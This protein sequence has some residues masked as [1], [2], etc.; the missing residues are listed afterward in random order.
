M[1]Q[2]SKKWMRLDNAANIYPA[3]RRRGWM[4][5]FR[6]SATLNEKINPVILQRAQEI[7]LK[8][9]PSMAVKLKRGLFWY[10]LERAEGGPQVSCD[11]PYPC[12]SFCVKENGGFGFRVKYY[13]NRIA[14][15]VFHVLTD[16]TGGIIFLKTL[17]AEYLRL[18]HGTVIPRGQEIF[19]CTQAP[20]P[21][22]LED[23]FWRYSGHISHGRSE[24][25]AYHISG[26]PEEGFVNLTTGLLPVEAVKAEAQ[27]MGVTVTELLS[28]VMIRA[29][30]RLQAAERPAR[31]QR[32]VK[33]MIPVNLR[34]FFFSRTVRNF[35]LYV[36]P[37]IDPRM[38]EYSLEEIAGALHHQMGLA[39]TAKQLAARFT[40]NVKSERNMALRIM[41]LFIKNFAM[42][43]VYNLIGE[44]KT[45]TT[46]TNLG[47]VVLPDEMAAYVQRMDFVLGP[48]AQNPLACACLS[49]QGI[50]YFS[51]CRTI[52]E[53]KWEREFF[54]ELVQMGIP[55]KI[56]SNM[57]W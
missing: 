5:L 13:R 46:L 40:T 16:G 49:Y 56:E 42:K 21:L 31:R 11:G 45:C 34:R 14:L 50:L 33:I 1:N 22:E 7:T 47:N 30:V 12:R 27:K 3:A 57:P 15:E 4:S 48:L 9:F 2:E 18:K 25:N 37:G 20:D 8:R 28:S 43:C 41:P 23:S 53:P 26:T 44:R 10:Y 36:S 35:S 29:A 54:T 52:Q 6:L 19:D 38:G 32:P 24:E 17:V 39:L 51:V 55:V